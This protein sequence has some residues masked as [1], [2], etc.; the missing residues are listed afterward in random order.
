M[1]PGNQLKPDSKWF[2]QLY[3]KPH[4][5]LHPE[6]KCHSHLSYLFS[7]FWSRLIYYEGESAS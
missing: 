2:Y 4:C 7:E 3:L 1:T 5:L 6:E